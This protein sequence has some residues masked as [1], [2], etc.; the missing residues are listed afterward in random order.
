[1]KKQYSFITTLLLTASLA[2]TQAQNADSVTIKKFFDATLSHGKSYPWLRDLTT[3]IGGRL[4]GSANAAKAVQWG[5]SVLEQEGADKV[6]LQDVMV[7][8][9]ERG[10]KEEAYILNGKQ[11]INVPLLALGGSIATPKKGIL[12]EVIEVKNFQE[13]RALGKEKCEGKIIFFNRPMD[14]TKISTF[15]AYG[16][17]G[18]QRRSGA[19]EASKVGAVGCIIRSLSNTL[20]DYPH[21]GSMQYATGVPLIPAGAISTNAAELLSKTLQENPTTKFFFKQNCETL[22]DAPSHNV[23]AELKGSEKPDEIIVVG[24]HLDSWDVAQGAH[25]DG[26]GIVQ[27]ME[28]LRLFKELGIKPKRTIRVVLFMNEENGNRG[29]IKYAELAKQN[30][31]KHIFALESDNGGFTPRGFGIQGGSP[32]VLA[33]IQGYKNLLAP[34]GLHEIEKGGGGVDIGPLAPQGTVLI[35]FKPDP[36]RYFEYHHASNDKFETVNQRELEMGA[37][38]MASLI[39]LLD[40]YGL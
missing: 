15:E 24:G 16:Q 30:N 14:P 4:A 2:Q 40:K 11:K 9:W 39:Y 29:G 21:T 31:E 5:K 8:H 3:N 25:D 34:Y 13:L 26:T 19:N 17:A 32:A 35:G 28:V 12:A 27:S 18:D 7:P 38:S 33:K 36:Q 1:M 6:F 22:D 37:A 23:V 10:A 20:N